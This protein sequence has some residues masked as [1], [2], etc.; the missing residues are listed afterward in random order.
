MASAGRVSV[1]ASGGG[2]HQWARA[3]FGLKQMLSG[4]I[5]YELSLI[6]IWGVGGQTFLGPHAIGMTTGWNEPMHREAGI[7]GSPIC[8]IVCSWLGCA[9]MRILYGYEPADYESPAG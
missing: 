6:T 4:F 3:L 8:A 1:R 5:V 9:P 2:P 7:S